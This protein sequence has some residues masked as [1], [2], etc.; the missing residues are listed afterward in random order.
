MIKS[1]KQ[2]R[3]I[4]KSDL[5]PSKVETRTVLPVLTGNLIPK[6]NNCLEMPKYNIK[7]YKVDNANDLS[8]VIM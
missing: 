8:K 6:S 3:R 2:T 4:V 1:T 7:V 5:G